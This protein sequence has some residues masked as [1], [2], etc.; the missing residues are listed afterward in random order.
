ML[1]S[2]SE[3]MGE[4]PTA[5]VDTI[6]TSVIRKRRL[7]WELRYNEASVT[8]M[9]ARPTIGDNDDTSEW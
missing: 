9:D 3:K 2:A 4:L 7:R 8:L 1:T 5:R 6:V